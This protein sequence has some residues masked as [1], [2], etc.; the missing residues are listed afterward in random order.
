VR[1]QAVLACPR[2]GRKIW[3]AWSGYHRR[4]LVETKM[5]YFNGWANGSSWIGG[6]Y[7]KAAT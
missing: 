3:I 7:N 6:L 5:P 1:N 2:L 4:S